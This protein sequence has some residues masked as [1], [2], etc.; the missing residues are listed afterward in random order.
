MHQGTPRC[1]VGRVV[2]PAPTLTR[3]AAE[4][5]SGLD[6]AFTDPNTAYVPARSFEWMVRAEEHQPVPDPR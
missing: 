5:N 6:A 2:C 3:S 1:G 4:K